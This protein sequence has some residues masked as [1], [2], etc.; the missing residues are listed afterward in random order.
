MPHD[1]ISLGLDV[2]SFDDAKFA[3]VEKFIALFNTLEKYDGKVYNP[4]LGSGLVEFNSSVTKTTVLL[5]EL[6]SKINTLN[7][8]PINIKTATSVKA[9]RDVGTEVDNV[10]RKSRSFTRNSV[11]G[12]GKV[13]VAAGHYLNQLR[14]LAYILPGIGLAGIFNVAFQAISEVVDELFD[15]NTQF[16]KEQ[17]ELE[18]INKVLEN[19]IGLIQ[20]IIDKSKEVEAINPL[21]KVQ[22]LKDQQNVQEG[23]KEK[24]R[25]DLKVA[26]SQQSL[27]DI[28]DKVK[29]AFGTKEDPTGQ[30]Q[31]TF[32]VNANY[33]KVVE[34]TA[35][36]TELNK[37]VA[38]FN[39]IQERFHAGGDKA[40]SESDKKFFDKYV[41]T[42]FYLGEGKLS[43]QVTSLQ[44]LAQS[45][46]DV[47]NKKYKPLA[48]IQKE[49][50]DATGKL[51]EDTHKQFLYNLDEERKKA[52]EI[53][54]E[55]ITVD[56][57]QQRKK[58][59]DEITSEDDRLSAILKERN[60]KR[61]SNQAD[62]KNVAD[63][64]RTGQDTVEYQIADNKLHDE[65]IKAEIAYQEKF[66]KI[67][68]HYRI[69]RVNAQA[70]IDS[71][72]VE[73]TAITN[74]KVFENEEKSLD[75]RLKAYDDYITGKKKIDDIALAA[76]LQARGLNADD[77]TAR[78]QIEDEKSKVELSKNNL[79]ADAEQK[80]YNIV[81]T[82]LEKQLK[83]VV[84]EGKEEEDYTNEKY[85]QD[86][87]NLNEQL[88]KKEITIEKYHERRKKVDRTGRI[89]TLT[90][91]LQDDET[92]L[93]KLRTFQKDINTTTDLFR[94]KR[95]D[96]NT[97]GNK[98]EI[99]KSTGDYNASLKVQHDTDKAVVIQQ[100]KVQKDR[101]DI[102]KAGGDEET[103]ERKLKLDLLL[104]IEKALYEGTKELVDARYE[105]KLAVLEKEKALIDEQYAY[106][107]KA[108]ES[109]SLTQKDK[110]A[111]EI[112]VAQQKLEK[113]KNIAAEERKIKIQEAEFDK[114][115]KIGN[116]IAQTALNIVMFLRYPVL[117]A[118]AIALGAIELATV[119]AVPI[120]TF[121][122]GVKDFKGGYAMTGE[123][124]VEVIKEPYRSPYLVMKETISYLPKGTE[125]IPVKDFESP[126][127][128][129]DHSWEQTRWLAKQ[130]KK[131]NKDVINVFKPVINIDLGFEHHKRKILGN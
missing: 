29:A 56:E 39:D 90:L 48:D 50:N 114:K 117:E 54:K 14:Q 24:S 6:N 94:L 73:K 105:H 12:L 47:A 2:T 63:N 100:K 34:A 115:L 37:V 68:D 98:F 122:Q 3:R 32:T 62:F 87:H 123:D 61:A 118:E 8:K 99:D 95:D 38:T 97:G 18:A 101:L 16:N 120:P 46:V 130:M 51:N 21:G 126:D 76:R 127:E 71:N 1:F 81:Y 77:P 9:V 125:V 13:G 5:D 69:L 42:G 53:S 83:L 113:D 11:E 33:A 49:Y 17:E 58:L 107:Q 129:I 128:K 26:V 80:N 121:A 22:L 124:G 119:I 35:K 110:A 112:Q 84:D 30:H 4:I 75:D 92:E 59:E 72:L 10:D 66:L 25:L 15:V 20:N 109:S 88:R 23:T 78:L 116:I 108:I 40:V 45:E 89:E 91:Q 28:K 65:N 96:A 7:D 102:E 55:N 79:V 60:D 64:T 82:S 19:Q 43:S 70:D 111:L 85:I 74:E 41:E 93:E 36:L 52:Y 27:D 44:K 103:K 131:N 57:A 31:I 67:T 104:K 106:E 86:L